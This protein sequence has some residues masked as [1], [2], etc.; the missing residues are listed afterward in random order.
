MQ[1]VHVGFNQKSQY[2]I[3][4]YFYLYVHLNK[5]FAGVYYKGKKSM[6]YVKLY[7]H[8]VSDFNYKPYGNAKV[9]KYN[10]QIFFCFARFK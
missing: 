4:E 9:N 1:D 3:S 6:I 10:I 7:V 8:L 5:G 2:V